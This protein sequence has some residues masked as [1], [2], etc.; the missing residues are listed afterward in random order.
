[1]YKDPIVGETYARHHNN[2]IAKSFV[3]FVSLW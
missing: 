1:M 3:S 2:L